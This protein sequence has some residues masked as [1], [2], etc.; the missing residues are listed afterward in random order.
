MMDNPSFGRRIKPKKQDLHP[1]ERA[2]LKLELKAAVYKRLSKH[3]Q[4]QTSRFSLER[5]HRLEQL[6]IRDGYKPALSPEEIEELKA[7]QSYPGY[8]WNGDIV[9][10]ESDLGISGTKGQEERPGLAQLIQLIEGGQ[11][12]S[13]YCVDV[14]RLFR[15]SDLI[16]APTFARLCKD[17]GVI[18]IAEG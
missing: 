3:E 11:V 14:T 10:I 16:T 6:A 7:Q 5:Q 15:D 18:I 4:I 17:H 13:I 12:E 9:V 1:S 8:Y 2:Q